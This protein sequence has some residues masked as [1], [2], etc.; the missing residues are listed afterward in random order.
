MWLLEHG[1]DFKGADPEMVDIIFAVFAPPGDRRIH[2]RTLARIG[3]LV[4]LPDFLTL[5]RVRRNSVDI[6]TLIAEH[7]DELE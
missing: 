5:M 3:Q 2:L 7:E 4:L 1:I 6:R